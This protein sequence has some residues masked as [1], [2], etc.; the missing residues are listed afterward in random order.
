MGPELQGDL[1]RR[2]R[3][4]M[5]VLYAMGSAT[6]GEILERIPDP[7]SYSAVRATMRVLE[8]KGHLVHEQDGPR[9]LYRPTVEQD[10]ARL[11]ALKHLVKTFFNGSA[12]QAAAALLQLSD[13]AA[14]DERDL[15]RLAEQVDRARREGR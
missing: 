11:A 2:E 3:Q 5:D 12:Q 4:I 10:H 13:H 15:S 7:P 8:E 9:Y 1:S 6:V 14:L